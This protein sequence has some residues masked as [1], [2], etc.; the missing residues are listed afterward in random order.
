MKERILLSTI[1]V[2]SALTATAQLSLPSYPPEETRYSGTVVRNADGSV[3]RS[4]T[5]KFRSIH[6]CPAT[7]LHTGSCPNYEV[8]HIYP[9][10]CGGKDEVANM[11]WMRLDAK[12]IIDSY[13]LY[14]WKAVPEGA[15]KCKFKKQP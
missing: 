10:G 8:A 12:A 6:V 9:L 2:L 4:S 5:G 1:L 11:V 3:K 15:V 14:M 13:E 7:G